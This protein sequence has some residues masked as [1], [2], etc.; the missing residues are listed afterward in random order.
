VCVEPVDVLWA[1]GA[2]YVDF[3]PVE[4]DRVVEL[5]ALARARTPQLEEGRAQNPPP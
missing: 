1:V 5:L 4:E 2:S 3:A